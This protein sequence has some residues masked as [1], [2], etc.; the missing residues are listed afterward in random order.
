M[1]KV[2]NIFFIGLYFDKSLLIID[3]EGIGEY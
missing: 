1:I 2:S 3:E